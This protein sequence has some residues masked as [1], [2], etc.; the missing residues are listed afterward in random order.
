MQPNNQL[1]LIKLTDKD[2]VDKLINVD[3]KPK[4][5]TNFQF[6]LFKTKV[7]E[8]LKNYLGL[9]QDN[10]RPAPLTEI[11]T[12][13]ITEVAK[14]LKQHLNKD[15]ITECWRILQD[16]NGGIAQFR[17]EPCNFQGAMSELFDLSVEKKLI[18]FQKIN[19]NNRVEELSDKPQGL[20]LVVKK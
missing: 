7:K 6:S 13:F 5:I 10:Q 18:N 17:N 20:Q 1:Q 14:K 2:D 19:L 15:S 16:L 11:E 8:F 3:E 9:D 12:K 4:D